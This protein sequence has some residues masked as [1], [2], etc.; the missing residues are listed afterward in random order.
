QAMVSEVSDEDMVINFCLQ[1]KIS[2]ASIE[3]LL[4]RGYTS[5]EALSLVDMSDLV[6][7]K[8]PKGQ[9]RLIMHI[10]GTLKIK[11]T[12]QTGGT[13]TVTDRTA[14]T[15][16]AEETTQT[17]PFPETAE[18]TR[19]TTTSTDAVPA[20]TLGAS[21]G[22]Q[23]TSSNNR[24]DDFYQQ[25]VDSLRREQ[26]R[27]TAGSGLATATN[28]A[29]QMP[30]VSW[31]DPQIHLSS[32]AGKSVSNY[33]D[34]CDFVS[35]SVEE[36]VVLGGQGDRQ[37]IV[38]SGPSKPRLENV[39]LCQW[40]VANLAILYKL[41]GENKLSGLSLMDYLSYTTKIYQLVQR[42]TLVSVLFYDRE[43]R[44]LQTSLNFRWGTDIQHLSNVHL[45]A[46]DRPVVQGSQQKKSQS[47]FNQGK[48]KN[49]SDTVICRNFNSQKGCTL[50]ECKF[51]HTCIIPGCGKPHSA[52]NHSAEK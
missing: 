44:K 23:P 47:Q 34:I 11:T 5:L 27:L 22:V 18:V 46:R 49:K 6:T 42:Y 16:L 31:S 36:E 35:S 28:S 48:G 26:Q 25:H 51:K 24:S 12:S 32:A 14:S 30:Q 33:L 13:A 52:L 9:R 4:K 10:A 39:T 1:H 41:V 37:I 29:M 21:N 20:F 17:I 15:S 19:S 40:S 45:Q 8:I 43:Y 7:P 2:R 3:E 50:P 38:K